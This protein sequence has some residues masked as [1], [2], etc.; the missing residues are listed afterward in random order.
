MPPRKQ[1]PE[2]TTAKRLGSILKSSRTIMRKDKGLS[3][4]LDR[5][6]LLTWLLFLK[7]LDDLELIA[8]EEAE[9]AGKS[10]RP[11]IRA[12]YRWRDWASPGSAI[13][14]PEL[15][16][17]IN[18]E[19]AVLS[20]G[21]RGE[22][23][24]TYLRRLQSDSGEGREDVVAN[25][26][27]GVVNRMESGYLLRDVVEKL[28]GVHFDSSEEVHTLSHL[29][30]SMLREMRDAAGDSGEF[31]TP[32]SVV[33]F[34]VE[35]VDPELGEVV[36]DPAAGTGGFLV[37]AFQHLAQQ[38][39][40]V[41]QRKILQERSIRGNEAKPLPYMLLQMNLLLHGLDYPVISYGNL[42]TPN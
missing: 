39:K 1:Q 37:E 25:V 34:M 5:L 26:F 32:R 38:A 40:T 13:T 16:A 6:P 29:Y 36:L 27:R 7:F 31:Y 41:Q 4:E 35:A 33:K 21:S 23:L 28:N 22:G 12:P 3:G 17:F 30:E 10:Y 2:L 18:Q 20:G 19:E 42:S 24:L 15:I 11:M 9:V 8:E 14:G